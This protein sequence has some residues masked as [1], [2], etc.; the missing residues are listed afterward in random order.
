M[1]TLGKSRD[2]KEEELTVSENLVK[3]VRKER[4]KN[5]IGVLFIHIMFCYIL[6]MFLWFKNQILCLYQNCHIYLMLLNRNRYWSSGGW[7]Y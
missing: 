1:S 3:D 2:G 4:I 6:F 7:K 5:W